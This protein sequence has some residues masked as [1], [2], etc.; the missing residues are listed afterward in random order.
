[1]SG[2]EDIIIDCDDV[3]ISGSLLE[4][5]E[6]RVRV[7]LEHINGSLAA[8]RGDKAVLPSARESIKESLIAV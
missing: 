8:T 3:S 5:C 6:C 2:Q 1:M 4:I 7:T